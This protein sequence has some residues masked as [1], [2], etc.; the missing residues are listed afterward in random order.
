M[1]RLTT[2]GRGR[3]AVL[4]AGAALLLL[5]ALQRSDDPALL[6]RWSRS[7]AAL[8]AVGAAA[9]LAA[10]L[11]LRRGPLPALPRAAPPAL[12]LAVPLLLAIPYAHHRFVEWPAMRRAFDER[13]AADPQPGP[14]AR[15]DVDSRLES[16]AIFLR[17]RMPPGTVLMTDV[18]SMLQIM[19][20]RRCI[21]F[22]YRVHPPEVLTGNADLVFY[23]RE[24]P[25]AS[26]VMDAVAPR[27]E[28]VFALPAVDDGGRLVT[29]TVYR[30]R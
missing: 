25:E 1:S 23:T 15:I 26:A 18:P 8:L 6:G 13:R 17:D 5:L 2:H 16:V 3:L 28:P 7:Y 4:A 24:I 10:L 9:W 14:L 12:L 19:S 22:V 30:T 27:L 29:P 21:P 20:G 11:L